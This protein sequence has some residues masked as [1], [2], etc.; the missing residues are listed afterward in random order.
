[1]RNENQ[2]KKGAVMRITR[3]EIKIISI[4]AYQMLRKILVKDLK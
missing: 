4:K 3:E 1:M 2:I